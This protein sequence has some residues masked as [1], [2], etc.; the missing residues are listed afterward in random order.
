MATLEAGDVVQASGIYMVTHDPRHTAEHE[1]TVIVGKK[2]PPCNH[3]GDHSRFKAVR[4]AAHIEQ[5][6]NFK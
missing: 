2:F 3:C 6:E 1:V 5:N 4:L